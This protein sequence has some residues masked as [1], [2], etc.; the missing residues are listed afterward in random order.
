MHFI[1]CPLSSLFPSFLSFIRL[2]LWV[3]FVHG[4]LL[5]FETD[6]P[7][8]PHCLELSETCLP[9]PPSLVVSSHRVLL[10]H[11]GTVPQ[12]HDLFVV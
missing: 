7:C 9:L 4:G 8:L 2:W 3:Y 12:F 10:Q 11:A 1:S 6:P 5:V